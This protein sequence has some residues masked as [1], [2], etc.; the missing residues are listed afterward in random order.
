MDKDIF[1]KFLNDFLALINES[2]RD[3][4]RSAL[5]MQ[6]SQEKMQAA[7]MLLNEYIESEEIGHGYLV[8]KKIGNID[9]SKTN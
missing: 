9:S 7:F 2:Q 6:A 1:I 8:K 4:T 3:I 5:S